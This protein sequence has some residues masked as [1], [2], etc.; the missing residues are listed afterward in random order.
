MMVKGTWMI[1]YVKLINANKDR[2][3]DKYLEAS[4]WEIVNNRVLSSVWYPY[5][6]FN[7]IGKAVFHEV[8]G[9]NLEVVRTF[10]RLFADN[11]VKVYKNVFIEGD[12]AA[13]IGKIYSLQGS[14]FRDIP[15]VIEPVLHEKNRSVVRINVSER[16]RKIGA[17]EAFAHQ[18][19]GMLE[20]LLEVSGASEHEVGIADTETG[21][22]IS[23]DWK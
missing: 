12:P 7:R 4:D 9:G 8:A 22:E 23:L 15:S 11:L 5:D 14:F 21:Y 16:E 17:V 13:T 10:G 6:S 2:D 18:F 3:W 1:D 19:A 20:R